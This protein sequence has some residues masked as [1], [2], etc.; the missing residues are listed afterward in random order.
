M[1]YGKLMGV[2]TLAGAMLWTTQAG[3]QLKHLTQD[4]Q[5]GD[6]TVLRTMYTPFDPENAEETYKV[7]T[8]VMDFAGETPIT[9]GV[10][11]QFSHHRGLYIG[12]SRTM[13]DGEDSFDTWHMP[14]SYQ[15]HVEWLHLE[16]GEGHSTQR[17]RIDWNTREDETLIREVREI[18][19]HVA[20]DGMRVIRFASSLEAVVGDIELRGDSHHAGMQIRM[21]NEVTEHPETTEYI[22]PEGAERLDN[23][24]V[25]GG[26][27]AAA[28]V[29]VGGKRYW[30]LHM[31]PQDHVGGEPLY[32]IRPY[33][34]FGAFT[35]PDIAQGETLEM[36]FV[37]IISEQELDQA[38]CQALYNAYA[39][40]R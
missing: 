21:S 6:T 39:D 5:V 20:P 16:M 2:L 27:W 3:A 7:Y 34:R 17:Q 28:G 31:T 9:K 24:E 25:S 32:S 18:T 36:D 29:D 14:N 33:A 10:G 4:L 26:W 13:L 12:W 19:A 11:G 40:A 8:H 23:D 1:K 30:V 15:E 37:V 38:A 22:L 35:E